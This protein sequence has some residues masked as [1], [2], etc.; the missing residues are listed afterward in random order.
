MVKPCPQTRAVQRRRLV[1]R[2][3]T[4]SGTR[5]RNN[6]ASNGS[7]N[8]NGGGSGNGGGNDDG[9]ESGAENGESGGESGNGNGGESGGE[10]AEWVAMN[11]RRSQK[12]E[13]AAKIVVPKIKASAE[14]GDEGH[15]GKAS[16]GLGMIEQSLRKRQ[17][18]PSKAHALGRR[19]SRMQNVFG[20]ENR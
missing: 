18:L 5:R 3:S 7:S 11:V 6:A 8:G 14:S 9:S 17:I 13:K 10:M 19:S 15:D 4:R 16:W 2:R 12:L 20:P 1:S